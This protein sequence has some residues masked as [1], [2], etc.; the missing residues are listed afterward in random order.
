MELLS[1]RSIH[2]D[3]AALLLRLLYGG[4]FVYYGYTK[5]MSYHEILPQFGDIIGI[6]S[7][8]SFILVIGAELGC[9]LLVALG[10]LTRIAVIPVFITMAVAYFIAHA[11][12]PLHAKAL[13]LV[14]LVMSVA[15]FILGSGKFSMDRWLFKK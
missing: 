5:L 8:L 12:D 7:K 10:F 11:H 15:I 1:T 6:G 3:L 9:G 13:A 14:F 2:T 4:L